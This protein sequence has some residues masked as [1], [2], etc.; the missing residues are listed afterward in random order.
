[1]NG[2]HEIKHLINESDRAQ[3]RARLRAVMK[4]DGHGG[5]YTVRSLYF[6]NFSD[7]AVLDKLSGQSRREKFRFRLYNGD[8]SFIRL[9]KKSK[10][11]RLCYKESAV[12]G[13]EICAAVL[14]GDFSP[15][16]NPES[17]L[18]TELYAKMRGQCL[19][20]KNV[21]EYRRE[22]YLYRPGNVRVT[23][24]SGIRTSN[25]PVGFLNPGLKTIPAAEG[26]V[27]EI[28]YDAFLPDI[29]R[30]LLQIGF[31]NQTEFSKYVVARLV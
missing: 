1:M 12:L 26:I 17:P 10:I 15:L 30:D 9:E 16:N 7:K 13:A 5:A 29:I 19:R 27:L 22:A 25:H 6:D 24:D 28:K 8:T 14:A 31:R 20:P 3:L 18:M 2:R 4:P 11:N 21:V 23:F